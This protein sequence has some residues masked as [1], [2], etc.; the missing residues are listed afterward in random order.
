M[1][2]AADSRRPKAPKARRL[3]APNVE[4]TGIRLSYHLT[5]LALE[6]YALDFALVGRGVKHSLAALLAGN[7]RLTI[8]NPAS[9]QWIKVKM[10]RRKGYH[11]TVGHRQEL[12]VVKI[13]EIKA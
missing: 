11:R 6:V 9:G 12:T 2:E 8:T 7:S 4:R 5:P 3:A 10:K 1:N 13:K